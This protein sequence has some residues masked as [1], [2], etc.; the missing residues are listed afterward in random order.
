LQKWLPSGAATINPGEAAFV[1]YPT[2]GTNTFIGQVL[3]GTNSI[4]YPA[5]YSTEAFYAPISGGLQTVMRYVPQNG[6]VVYTYN[7]GSQAY[8][9]ATYSGALSKWL[10]AEPSLGVGQGIFLKAAGA[11]TWSQVFT[12][13]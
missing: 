13:Q 5:G 1:K 12:N 7:T 9:N 6:D 10:P 4:A 2:A 11:S 3:P 8:N